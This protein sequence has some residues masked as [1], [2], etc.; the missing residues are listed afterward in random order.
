V[1]TVEAESL[2]NIFTS[3]KAPEE[4]NDL[5]EEEEH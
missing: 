4:T 1:K 2:F 5:E 3:R